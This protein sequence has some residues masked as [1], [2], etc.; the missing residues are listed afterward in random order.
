[1]DPS[2]LLYMPSALSE[3]FQYTN[4]PV[5]PIDGNNS[6]T[7]GGVSY[8]YTGPIPFNFSGNARLGLEGERFLGINCWCDIIV[9]PE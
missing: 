2:G 5:D 3:T 4:N 6:G 7:G 9:N 8:D 1:M